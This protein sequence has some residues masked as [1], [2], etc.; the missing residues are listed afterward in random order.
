MIPFRTSTSTRFRFTL[1]TKLLILSIVV[2]SV[3]YLGYEYMRGLEQHLRGNLEQSLADAARTIA[4]AMHENYQLF[5]YIDPETGRSL[6]IHRLDT[7]VQI[8]GYAEDW[9]NYLDWTDDYPFAEQQASGGPRSFY[10]LILAQDE[11]YLYAL[12][13]VH[14]DRIIYHHPSSEQTIDSDYVELVLGDDYHVQERYYFLPSAPGRFNPIQIENIPGE[15]ESREYIRYVTNIAADWQPGSGGYN[16]EISMPLYLVQERMGFV[17]GDVDRPET[18]EIIRKTGT[19]GV[20]TEDRPGRLIRPSNTITQIIKRNLGSAGRRIWVLDTQRQV[21]ASTGSLQR[22]WMTHPLNFFYKMLLPS[23]TD[24]FKDDLAGASRLQGHEIQGALEGR[25][26]SRWRLSPDK[27]AVIVSAAAPIW[28]GDRVAGAVMVEETTNNIQILQRNAM[29]SLINKTL[30]AFAIVT[31]A[32]LGFATRLSLRLR[33]LSHEAAAAVDEQ[34]RVTGSM[35]VSAADDEIGDLSRNYAAMLERLRQ[36]N[37]YL[38]SLAGKLSH[39]LRTPMAVVQSSLENLRTEAAGR[40]EVYLDRAQEGMR[41]LNLL[42]TR[43]SEA[44]RL[45]QAI[46]SAERETHDLCALLRK[47]VD[48]YRAVWPAHN[49]HLSVPAVEVSLRISRDLFLQM[50][51]KLIA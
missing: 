24:R 29:V 41:R 37:L 43:L 5:P 15:W 8:D 51:D 2:L 30:A 27:K 34:G 23:V 50:L 26:E 4:G 7:P 32:L 1:R 10:K 9:I 18:R 31:L 40:G 48:G 35:S 45:E 3:P 21:L 39:E 22:E 11:Q 16:L 20:N 46:Q 28:L 17:V 38:E 49:F 44:A 47:S 14:D 25:T 13:Q 36:Y 42:V 6:F 12:L 19:A 33:R